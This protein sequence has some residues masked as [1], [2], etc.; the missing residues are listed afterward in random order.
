VAAAVVDA[1]D[2]AVA[3]EVLATNAAAVSKIDTFHPKKGERLS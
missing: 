1:A 2:L 3:A